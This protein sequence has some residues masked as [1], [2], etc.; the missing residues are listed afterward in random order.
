MLPFKTTT[1]PLLTWTTNLLGK[2]HTRSLSNSSF[3][4]LALTKIQDPLDF[5]K[6][7]SE[8]QPVAENDA[9]SKLL[10][11]PDDDIEVTTIQ[12]QHR[13]VHHYIPKDPG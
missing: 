11:F 13:T 9:D 8:N 3:K 10:E 5:E 4:K 12:R 7:I 2:K 1:V 6:Y